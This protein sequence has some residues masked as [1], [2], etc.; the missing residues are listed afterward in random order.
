MIRFDSIRFRFRY[1]GAGCD[2][3]SSHDRIRATAIVDEMD[4][5]GLD[6]WIGLERLRKITR[7][8]RGLGVMTEV[9]IPTIG[10]WSDSS[11]TGNLTGTFDFNFI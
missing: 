7:G 1:R 5:I 6:F 10:I 9:Q 3:G 11:A 4:S 8:L 2:A